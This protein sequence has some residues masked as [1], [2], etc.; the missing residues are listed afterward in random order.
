MDP[1]VLKEMMPYLTFEFGNPGSRHDCGKTAANAVAHARK[2]VADFFHCAPEQVIF[3]SGG[4]EGNNLV[5][6]GLEDELRKRGQTTYLVSAVEHDSVLNAV[7]DMCIK[8]WFDCR[9]AQPQKEGNPGCIGLEELTR[10]YGGNVGLVSVMAANN[11]TGVVNDVLSIGGFC[12]EHGVLFHTDAVQLAGIEE[13]DTSDVFPC[14]FM[15]VSSHKIHGPKGMGA[16][17]ARDPSLLSP[18]ISGGSA[19]EFG[20]R[21]GTENVAGI[22]GFGAACEFTQQEQHRH[23]LKLLQEHRFLRETLTEQAQAAGLEMVTHGNPSNISPKTLNIAFPGI[24]AETMLIMLNMKGVCCSAGSACTAHENTPSHVLT[25]MGIDPEE[26]RC[27]IRLSLSHMTKH[28][29]LEEAAMIII[30]SARAIKSMQN[31]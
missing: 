8:R 25:A 12:R 15:T 24:D 13:L 11:E 22:V 28:E 4:S 23:F 16:V 1:R 30:E 9:I 27:S 19:Q 5:I 29:E 31:G 26:A 2:Q 7:R 6:K 10:V 14:D 3:T 17:F 20:F 21:G 18:L